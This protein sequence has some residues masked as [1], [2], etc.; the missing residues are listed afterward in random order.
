MNNYLDIHSHILPGVDDGAQDFE[1]SL[2][3]IRDAYA[4]G[5]R[6]MVATPHFYPHGRYPKPEKLDSLFLELKE[7]IKDEFPDL[8][9]MLGNEIYYKPGV[10]DLLKDKTI[11]T[12]ND[13]NYVLV[14]FNVSL[15]YEKIYDAVKK[16]TTA[17]YYPIIAHVERYGCLHKREDL[18][19]ELTKLGAYIQVNTETFLGGIFDQYTKFA[20]KLFNLGLVHFL[21]SDAHNTDS[22]KAVMEKAISKL[23]KKAAPEMLEKVLVYNKDHFINNL[24]I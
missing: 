10:V 8:Q 21:G 15:E 9:L 1:S 14:E 23:S 16:L 5:V 17:G 13:G 6:I 20:L 19:E 7:K 4:E 18:V 24:F 2:A 3:I 12:L 22:R 11:H